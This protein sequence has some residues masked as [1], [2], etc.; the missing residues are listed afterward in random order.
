MLTK[1]NIRSDPQGMVLAIQIAGF[2]PFGMI[3]LGVN[4]HWIP[5]AKSTVTGRHYTV[6]NGVIRSTNYKGEK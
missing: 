2:V 4:E 3:L 1:M 5:V 6:T